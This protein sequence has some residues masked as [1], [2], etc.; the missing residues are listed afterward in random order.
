MM[1][2][3]VNIGTL[4]PAPSCAGSGRTDPSTGHYR[5]KEKEEIDKETTL[6]IACFPGGTA[7]SADKGA[8][9]L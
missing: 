7:V 9:V 3:C 6:G 4:L 1:T 2:R 5:T 8:A